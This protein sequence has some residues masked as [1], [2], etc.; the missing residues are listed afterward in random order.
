[1]DKNWG[2]CYNTLMRIL[3]VLGLIGAFAFLTFRPPVAPS[4]VGMQTGTTYAAFYQR[5][6]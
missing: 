3:I 5:A 1:M 4:Q 6:E 2:Q